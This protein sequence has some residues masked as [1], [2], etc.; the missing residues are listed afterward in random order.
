MNNLDDIILKKRPQLDLMS[1]FPSPLGIVNFGEISRELNKKLVND[2]DIEMSKN[3]TENRSFL[4]NGCSWQSKLGQE[5]K[6][7]SFEILRRLINSTFVSLLNNIFSKKEIIER[8]CVNE[9][10]SNVIFK[11][12]GWSQPHIHENQFWTGVYYPKSIESDNMNLDVFDRVSY[13]KCEDKNPEG[14]SLILV[15]PAKLTKT[16]S[17]NKRHI[18]GNF[19]GFNYSLTPREGILILFPSNIEH[20]VVPV[21]PFK[22]KRYSI[23]FSSHVVK[24]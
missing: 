20:Y 4:D 6:Y 11:E 2:I 5:G 19:G 9:L 23:S 13:L 12:G 14:G 3:K 16:L 15:D 1:I 21:V 22:E 8:V 17:F 10:W 18:K 24:R 7:K